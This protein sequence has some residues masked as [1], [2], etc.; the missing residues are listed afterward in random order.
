MNKKKF[1]IIGL[2]V[3]GA[4][5]EGTAESIS[6]IYSRCKEL[7]YKLLIFNSF[8]D[9]YLDPSPQN[10]TRSV[11]RII[12][13]DI[14]DGII[15]LTETI[16]SA[17]IVEEVCSN[18]QS[19]NIPVSTII[20]PAEGCYNIAFD[21]TENF[22]KIIDHVIEVH[23]CKRI[24]FIS[25]MKGNSFAEERLDC[26]RESM[27]AHGLEIDERGIGYGN[28]WNEPT[29]EVIEKW[30]KDDN[31]P[32]PDAIICANDAMAIAT[33]LKLSEYGYKVPEDIIVT[34]HDGIQAEKNHSPRLTNAIT[35]IQGASYRAVDVIE[36]VLNGKNPPKDI[37]IPSSLVFSESCGCEPMTSYS[38]NSKVM[39]LSATLEQQ[40]GF[41]NHLNMMAMRLSE[42]NDFDTFRL[43]LAEYMQS[44]WS[45]A[46]WICMSA[47]SMSP[48]ALTADELADDTTYDPP[49]TR[50][51]DGDKLVNVMSW[52]QGMK[53]T[54]ST[55]SFDR[56]EILPNLIGKLEKYD[57]IFF[58]P[59][60]FR[61]VPQGYI[62]L[63]NGLDGDNP[64]KFTQTFMS[65]LNMI[66]EVMKQKL[67]INATVSQLK[68]MY[69]LDF[70]TSLY[71]RRGFYTK[72]KPRLEN[73]INFRHDL[74]VV[75]VDM[76][77]LKTIND[78]YGHAEGDNAIRKLSNLLCQSAD[79]DTIIA[80]F[81]GDEFVVAAVCPDGEKTAKKF[82]TT[83]KRKLDAYNEISGK[84]YK[85]GAS[86]GISV[87][88]PDENTN[89]DELIELADSI[90]YRQKAN[91]KKLRGP[92]N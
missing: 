59:I 39:E 86:I 60:Y 87:T 19:K 35:N 41:E 89:L 74:M 70:M 43:H 67:F 54:P 17:A 63:C 90:M 56:R 42:D 3:C 33:C 75:S 49:E 38:I 51:Y 80:R 29:Y 16:K 5:D 23:N 4:Q 30:I 13:Y 88:Q 53:Y 1:K 68:S 34:G 64:F 72:I 76:D 92:R 73:C 10:P 40:A 82:K 91:H 61:N 85:I 32:K 2:V 47:D 36:E 65:Y 8:A 22:R 79:I 37:V 71:N 77:G 31:L 52:E 50:F 20:T 11:F 27:K 55:I 83:L 48:R 69:I 78:T 24:Y 44:S 58:C 14:L 62:G 9:Y 28:F 45:H 15:L 84:P 81:G 18:A 21:F 26:Y 12:N 57:M 46:A 25:G 6:H 7:G 66:L